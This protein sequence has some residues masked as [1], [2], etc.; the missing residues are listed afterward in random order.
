MPNCP[1]QAPFANKDPLYRT[2]YAV[3]PNIS[4]TVGQTI[5]FYAINGNFPECVAV[6]PYNSTFWT[7]GFQGNCIPRCPSGTW[8]DPASKLC[9]SNCT[10]VA[11]PYKD[12]SSG[13]HICVFNCSG[14]NFFRDNTTFT[15]VTTCPGNLF[16]E[17]TRECVA[18]CANGSFGLPFGNRKCV[19]FCPQGW[20]GEPDSNVCVNTTFR[21]LIAIKNARRARSTLLDISDMQITTPGG[22]SSPFN[23]PLDISLIIPPKVASPSVPPPP[24][25]TISPT[26]QW[27]TTTRSASSLANSPFLQIMS[28]GFAC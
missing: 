16:G 28:Q 1:P 9:V 22:A 20:W 18:R 5:N 26:P 12:S 8:G 6:C 10:D 23:A 21:K 13:Q 15:C 14:L 4:N 17:T 3:C 19:A 7:F 25:P 11:F 27:R 24:L 2:C